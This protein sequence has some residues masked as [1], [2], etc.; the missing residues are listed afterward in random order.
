MRRPVPA[1]LLF[2]FLAVSS[3]TGQS[4]V[5]AGASEVRLALHKLRVLGSVLYVAAHPDDEN[6]AFLAA[7]ARGRS[8]RT[9]Y[10]SI[11]R[12][13]GGQNLIGT[14]QGDA[15]GMLRTQE[16]LAARRIDGAEQYFTRAIDFG[17]SKSTEETLRFWGR[18]KTLGD[19]VWVIRRFRPDVIVTRFTP[20]A[21]GHGNHTAS[22]TLALDAFSAAADSTRFKEQLAHVRPWAA[23][24]I[25]WNVFRS[26]ADSLPMPRGTIRLD[27]GVYSPLL[28]KSFAELAGEGRSMHKSQG[29]GAAQNRGELFNY[30]Q[31]MDG[32]TA[33]NDLLDGVQTSWVRIPGGAGVDSLFA[34][35]LRT[36]DDEHPAASLPQLMQAEKRLRSLPAGPWREVKQQELRRIIQAC[37]GLWVEAAAATPTAAPG[38]TL[39]VNVTV[40]N[41]SGYPLVLDRLAMTHMPSDSVL[42]LRLEPNKTFRVPFHFRIPATTPSSQPYWLVEPHSPGSYTLADARLAGNAVDDPALTLTATISAD[43]ETI[44]FTVPVVNKYIDPVDG[45][46]VRPFAIVPPVSIRLL[47]PV[48]L[49]PNGARKSIGISVKANTGAIEGTVRLLLPDNWSVYPASRPFHLTTADEESLV[50]FEVSPGAE[51]RSGTLKVEAEVGGA[52]IHCFLETINYKHVPRVMLLP[53]SEGKLLKLDV[54]KQGARI[55]YIMGPGDEVPAA[56]RQ[57]GYRV[58]L[59]SDD[60]LDEADLSIYDA[61]VAGVR[62]YNTRPRLR[63]AQQRL[64][65]YVAEGGTYVIQ[66]VTAGRGETELPGPYPI[67]L[68]R[69]RVTEEETPV[70]ILAPNHPLLSTPNRISAR[71]FEGWVQERGLYFADRWD[72]R[73]DSLLA[74]ADQGEPAR[75]GGLLCTRY[76]KGYFIYNAYAFFRQLPAGVE[77]AYRLFANMVSLHNGRNRAH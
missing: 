34:G 26:T 33:A 24:R 57:L 77:G 74:C 22:A 61:I 31:H 54:R 27:L 67:H 21:G 36:F 69:E 70:R 53:G 1:L 42:C 4:S 50:R 37:A 68:S 3:V 45:E 20:T 19:V 38:S 48:A 17:Y 62:A 46:V 60:D 65:E 32:D 12:G 2:S 59:V 10:L 55:G 8:Y 23:K 7:M 29:F 63:A 6:T 56:L 14:E 18:E 35:I 41:R 72:P 51:A 58:F 39:Q 44:G 11:T 15:L 13:E 43:G 40:V 16:L 25:A 9:A 75:A 30:F 28:G 64:L 49:F 47:E 73:Y 76:G 71:D 66:Y 5:P 52:R